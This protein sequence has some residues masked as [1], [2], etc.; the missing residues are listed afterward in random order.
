[1]KGEEGYGRF[2]AYMN[3]FVGAML[4]LLL[5]DNLLFLLVGWEGVGL[6]SYLLIGF[7][8]RD[9]A[10]GAA[11]RKAFIVTRIGD[12]SL[13]GGSAPDLPESRLAEHPADHG[14]GAAAL[15][16]RFGRG[17]GRR[18]SDPR[19]SAGQVGPVAAADLAARRD[20]RSHPGERFDPRRHHGHSRRLPHSAHAHPFRPGSGREDH[21]GRHRRRHAHLR[22][23]ERPG[24][25]R[26]QA[27]AG[28]FHHQPDRLHVPGPGSGGLVGG[29]LP[30]HDAR[31]LQSPA[32]PGRRPRHQGHGRGARHIQDGGTAP[33]PAPGLLGVPHRRGRPSP[34]C[35]L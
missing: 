10:N 22:R 30:L 19:R 26:H 29:D 8:Y 3:L 6:S 5:A 12:T 4:I 13:L 25:A 14:A 17:G 28:V 2:F 32:V 24:P 34:Q 20:G 23:V 18:A 9:P 1:M 33:E 31:V 16:A 21:G 11:A 27:S 7:W 15:A 35:P